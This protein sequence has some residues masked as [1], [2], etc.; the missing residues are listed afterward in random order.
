MTARRLARAVL[1]AALVAAVACGSDDATDSSATT[2]T[3]TAA[4][5]STTVETTTTTV[6]E[7]TA[8]WPSV[9]DT[10][11][12]AD[13]VEAAR[14]FATEFL[15]FVDPVVGTFQAGDSRSGE[16]A[17]RPRATGPVTTILLRQLSGQTTWSVLG[18]ATEDIELTSPAAGDEVTSPLRLE[19]RARAFEGT[20]DVELRADGTREPVAASYVTGGGDVM[21]PFTGSID[22]ARPATSHGALVLFTRSMENGEIWTAS[23]VRIAFG[24]S[25]GSACPTPPAATAGA[26]E[27]LVTV[28]FTCPGAKGDDT[29]VA[30]ERAMPASVGVLRAA[31]DALVAGPGETG[32]TSWFSPATA[33]VVRSVDIDDGHAVVDF[34]D[35]LRTLI[36]NASASAGSAMLLS[37]LDATVFHLPSVRTVEYRM[38]GSCQDFA[39]WLQ[40]SCEVRPRP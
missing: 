21:R 18:A 12:P 36:P 17:I 11:R 30:V 22:F 9:P 10:P 29:L 8:V 5:S 1:A 33:S 37:Q 14:R 38:G 34:V 16:V 35:E 4:T 19:G 24:G 2:T 31:L 6:V 26:G 23:V 20:V 7:D 32:L 13:P 3:S 28:F 39:E 27:M 40:L 15:G 25:T